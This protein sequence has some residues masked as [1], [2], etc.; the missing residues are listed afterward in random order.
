MNILCGEG[1]VC[2][3]NLDFLYEKK[4]V[5]RAG[6]IPYVID[7]FGETY[8]LLGIDKD[9]GVLADLGGTREKGETTL[10]V[11]IREFLE[12]SRNVVRVDL[13][14][15][16]TIVISNI[17]SKKNK[18]RKQVLFFTK[19]DLTN[20][21]VHIDEQFQKTIPKNKYEDEMSSLQW[22]KFNDFLNIPD[23]NLSKSLQEVKKL[24]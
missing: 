11:A 17:V 12:E 8:L 6:I 4:Y 22:F 16:S 3:E 2:P 23:V 18:I 24:F 5:A 10:D 19:I 13:N 14:K 9:S 21:N 1:I 7:K 15:T 20:Y